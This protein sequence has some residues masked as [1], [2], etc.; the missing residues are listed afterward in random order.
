VDYIELAMLVLMVVDLVVKITNHAMVMKS[1]FS[2]QK[3]DEVQ[4]YFDEPLTFDPFNNN[5]GHFVLKTEY[6]VM[7]AILTLLIIVL[8]IIQF[9]LAQSG[10]LNYL[11]VGMLMMVRAYCKLP[12]S[13]AIIMFIIKVQQIRM[14]QNLIFPKR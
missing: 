3:T 5:G 14:S 2:H 13:V 7:D 8:Y 4:I 11:H 10:E 6:I 1:N 9:S 12:L